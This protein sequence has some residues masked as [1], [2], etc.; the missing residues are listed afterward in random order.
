MGS[1]S[2]TNS[3]ERVLEMY[4]DEIR[5]DYL[6]EIPDDMRDTITGVALSNNTYSIEVEWE[7]RGGRTLPGPSIDIDTLAERYPDAD[8]GY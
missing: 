4:G 3:V 7:L 1:I 2:A 6:R 5:Q 8:V